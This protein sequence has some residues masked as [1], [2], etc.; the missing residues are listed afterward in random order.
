MIVYMFLLRKLNRGQK[1][2]VRLNYPTHYIDDVLS[3]FIV[4]VFDGDIDIVFR[5]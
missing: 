3:H 1:K 2:W 4:V 5:K